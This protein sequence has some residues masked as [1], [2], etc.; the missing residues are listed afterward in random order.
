MR[1]LIASGGKCTGSGRLTRKDCA[2]GRVDTPRKFTVSASTRGIAM[3]TRK[4]SAMG[5]G[6][7]PRGG[8]MGLLL[9]GL[10]TSARRGSTRKANS[11]TGTRFAVGF[12]ARRS[13]AS[14]K[15]GNGG[16]IHA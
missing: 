1:A 11:L 4:A 10:S 2:I 7:V 14:P 13:T 15:T 6:S 16:P 5:M 8:P 9:G 3:G 12:C